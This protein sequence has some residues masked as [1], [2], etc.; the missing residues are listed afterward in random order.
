MGQFELAHFQDRGA[1][2]GLERRPRRKAEGETET[3]GQAGDGH[4]A[5][6][7]NIGGYVE[8]PAAPR[9]N[10]LP[11]LRQQGPGFDLGLML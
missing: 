7:A 3:I 2:R 5:G 11:Q 6:H 1:S 4:D 8:Q 10:L 9:G